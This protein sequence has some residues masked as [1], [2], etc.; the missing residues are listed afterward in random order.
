MG[1]GSCMEL[2][3]VPNMLGIDFLICLFRECDVRL[4]P[5]CPFI[6]AAFDLVWCDLSMK[7]TN[8]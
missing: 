1:F 3:K 2:L 8:R 7:L 6:N 4:V 5:V